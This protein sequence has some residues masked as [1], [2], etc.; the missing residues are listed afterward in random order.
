MIRGE[1]K[2]VLG[3][4][5]ENDVNRASK[6][7]LLDRNVLDSQDIITL[8]D[9]HFRKTLVFIKEEILYF[10]NNKSTAGQDLLNQFFIS[11]NKYV[12]K[13]DKNQAFTP[14]HITDFMIDVVEVNR[15]SRVLAPCAEDRV[16]IVTK[17]D[18]NGRYW[19]SSSILKI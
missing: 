13:E 4:L 19:S 16:I 11:F 8:D 14:D 3:R 5:L 18:S 10:I 12:G 6:V 9:N 17:E 1:M 2:R 7:S 15:Y